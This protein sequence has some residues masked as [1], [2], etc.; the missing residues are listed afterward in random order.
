MSC[1]RVVGEGCG[2]RGGEE[3]RLYEGLKA[4]TDSEDEALSVLV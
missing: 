3:A 1:D 4:I 2:A